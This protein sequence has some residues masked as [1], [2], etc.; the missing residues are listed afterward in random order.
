MRRWSQHLRKLMSDRSANAT[1]LTSFSV[2]S[3]IGGA[4]IATDTVQ[5]TLSKRQLQRM[6]DSAALA[7]SF[8]Q[9]KG[10]TN[11][12]AICANDYPNDAAR[13]AAKVE[14]TR[15][16]NTKLLTM[17]GAPVIETGVIGTYKNATR[18]TVNSTKLL[19]F[20]SMFMSNTPTLQ[21]KAMAAAVGFGDYCVIAL[22]STASNGITFQ[23]SS[24]VNLQCG[25]MTNSQGTGTNSSTASVYAGGSSTIIASPISAVGLVPASTNYSSTTT[26]NSYAIPQPDPFDSVAL[27]TGYSCA[28]QLSVNSKNDTN[29]QNNGGVK[30]YR[31]MDLKTTVN[32][33]PGTYVIDG[34]NGGTLNVGAGA[35]VNCT[36]CTFILTTTGTDMT[37]VA[38][39]NM[40]GNA[41]WNVSA[42]ESGTYAGIMIYQDRGAIFS[43]GSNLVTGDNSSFM[44][45]AIYLPSQAVQFTGN[46]YMNTKCLQI[47]AR[48]VTFTGNNTIQN[49]CP[50]NSASKAIA[51]IQIRLVN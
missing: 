28:N 23:G 1:V 51:G 16:T 37:R 15:F 47:V 22:E 2:L 3:L 41:T 25:A 26:L 19:P 42:P 17:S 12:A 31:G 38:T 5:W 33:E 29:I 48:T 45:G 24:Y 32:F 6:A 50:T 4:G 39:V 27:P 14:L 35:V 13:C 46:A 49:E 30:C 43:A 7:G 36:G 8:T 34:S 10:N 18:V 44:Q 21:A 20:S 9:A 40:N 11:I